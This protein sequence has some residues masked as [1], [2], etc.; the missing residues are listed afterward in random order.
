MDIIELDDKILFQNFG[1]YQPQYSFATL[2]E[3]KD[4][5]KKYNC[6]AGM[7]NI[8]E[9]KIEPKEQQAEEEQNKEEI[10]NNDENIGKIAVDAINRAG[11][12]GIIKL[13]DSP[14]YD[15]YIDTKEG[16]RIKRGYASSYFITD[17]QTSEAKYK[18]CYL[19]LADRDID[20][21]I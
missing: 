19:C 1:V 9:D 20:S 12:Y 18:D 13:E 6:S 16:F 10:Q 5:F 2:D 14:T 4:A 3:Y 15:T 17:R 21:D 7:C 11:K 8:E